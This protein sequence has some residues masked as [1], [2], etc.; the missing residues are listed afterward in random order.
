MRPFVAGVTA[1]SPLPGLKVLNFWMRFPITDPG[2][3]GFYAKVQATASPQAPGD[4]GNA[5][6]AEVADYRAGK[7]VERL[8]FDIIDSTAGQDI[9]ARLTRLYA[10]AQ[11]AVAGADDVSLQFYGSYV[12]SGGAWHITKA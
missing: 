4:Y 2:R 1:D 12:D 3:V 11:T 7:F 8:G 5:D 10:L 9:E 6:A